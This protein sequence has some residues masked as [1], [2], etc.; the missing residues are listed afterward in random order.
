MIILLIEQHK[1]TELMDQ[2]VKQ[3]THGLLQNKMPGCLKVYN[4]RYDAPVVVRCL[5]FLIACVCLALH[6]F[7]ALAFSRLK[8]KTLK[9]TPVANASEQA[10]VS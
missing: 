10:M 6:A 4:Q 3:R 9:I 2:L 1:A 8:K 7:L 5:P